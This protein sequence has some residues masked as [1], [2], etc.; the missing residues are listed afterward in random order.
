MDEPAENDPSLRFVPEMLVDYINRR[1]E[2]E[3]EPA[4]FFIHGVCLL[5]DISGFTKL[6]SEYCSQGKSGIDSLQLATNGFMGKL[7]EIIY[8]FGG[9]I[10]K[11]AGDAIVCVFSADFITN[12]SSKVL[13]RSACGFESFRINLKDLSKSS[14]DLDAKSTK[15]AKVSTEVI[16]RVMHCAKVLR[17]VQT[18][19]LTVHV[20]MSCGEMCFGVL[21]GYENRWECLISGPCIHEL[22]GCLD[23]APSKHAVVSAG[24]VD[25]LV[26]VS[27]ANAEPFTEVKKGQTTLLTSLIK[28]NAGMYV[29]EILPLESGNFRIVDVQ[30]ASTMDALA[31]AINKASAKIK[32]NAQ[33]HVKL[34]KQFVPVPIAEE[35]ES[36]KELNLMAQIREVTTMF[37]KVTTHFCFIISC[38]N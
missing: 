24:C 12:V 15:T 9:D 29:F 16:L 25:I 5:V 18:D 3:L 38:Y 36:A 26:A 21:G 37:M 13:R 8:S 32:T 20:A 10:I 7:V 33:S 35:L 14:F 30:C 1:N 28:T 23:D 2:K 22:S 27:V 19:K 17:E 34:I 6:S 4:S 31:T 11:F